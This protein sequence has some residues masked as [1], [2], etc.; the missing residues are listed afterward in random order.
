MMNIDTGRQPYAG[1]KKVYRFP[2]SSAHKDNSKH[3]PWGSKKYRKGNGQLAMKE[4][5]WKIP[6]SIVTE[7][8]HFGHLFLP[9]AKCPTEFRDQQGRPQGN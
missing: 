2:V 1:S 4:A 7:D 3:T 6:I 5:I 9:L 8:S